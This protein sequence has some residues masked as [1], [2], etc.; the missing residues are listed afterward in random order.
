MNGFPPVGSARPRLLILGSFPSAASLEKGQYYGNMRNHFWEVLGIV[1]DAPFPEEYRARSRGAAAP[2]V[3]AL[4][5]RHGIAVWDV[6]ASCERAGS[7]D[8]D[9]RNGRPNPL[10]DYVFDHPSIERIALNGG[11]AA[12]SFIQHFGHGQMK[13]DLPIGSEI[14]WRPPELKGRTVLIA[15]LPSTSPIPTQECKTAKEK[16]Q[17]WMPFLRPAI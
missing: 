17:A 7:L 15:R 3:L 4:L 5:K 6:L 9:I 14:Q 1:L 16:A 12:S 13:R 10:I 11:R 8:K 2:G